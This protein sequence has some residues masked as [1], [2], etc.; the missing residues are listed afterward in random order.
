MKPQ[1]KRTNINITKSEYKY[2]QKES[3]EKSLSMSELIRRI[4]DEY[5]E[6][7]N[8]KHGYKK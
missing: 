4:L 8:N 5:I 3:E 1:L 2:L 6:E 7:K